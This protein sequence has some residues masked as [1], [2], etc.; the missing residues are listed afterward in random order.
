[1]DI[2]LLDLANILHRSHHSND[3]LVPLLV[4]T[5]ISPSVN[6]VHYTLGNVYA[7]SPCVCV[8]EFLVE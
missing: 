2:P 4:A 3:A 1:M 6:V 7:V 8:Y 5:S